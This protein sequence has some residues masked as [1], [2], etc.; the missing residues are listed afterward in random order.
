[1]L[2]SGRTPPDSAEAIVERRVKDCH[3]V[4]IGAVADL[5][6]DASERT[7]RFI[8]IDHDPSVQPVQGHRSCR[9]RP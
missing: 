5:V 9:S 8:Y 1:M 6:V 2:T 4:D 7:A 3:A